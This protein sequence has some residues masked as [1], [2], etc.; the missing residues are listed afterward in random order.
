MKII[1]Y[2]ILSL[3]T[4]F[5]LSSCDKEE[6]ERFN[7]ERAAINIGFDSADNLQQTATF[8]Y[9]EM[10]IER[11]VKFYARI[12]GVP[13]DYDRTFTIEAVDGDIDLAE[14][15]YRFDT[16]VIP[17]NQTSGEFNIYFDPAKLKDPDA[18]STEEGKLVFK[19]V[20]NEDFAEGA[21]N[22][23]ELNFTL[24]NSLS[25]PDNWDSA[26]GS[27]ALSTFF[28]TYSTEKFQ[29]MIERGC[30]MNFTIAYSAALPTEIVDGV[31]VMSS[32]YAEYLRQHYILELEDY[33]DTHDTPLCDSLGNPISFNY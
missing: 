30:P 3:A 11:A 5:A 23:N 25:K 19:T 21:F 29:F 26:V 13:V 15:S 1:R 17:A 24:R 33:N 27:F 18:F 32:S 4:I 14:G 22:Q 12:T 10:S 31:T 9:S 7:P 28:G 16:Y 6:V 2:S 8:N 20:A